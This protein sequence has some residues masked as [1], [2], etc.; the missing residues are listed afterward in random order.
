MII[1]P[2]RIGTSSTLNARSV[3]KSIRALAAT[4]PVFFVCF[5]LISPAASAQSPS[6]PVIE[7]TVQNLTNS[8]NAST[9][10]VVAVVGSHVYV[11]WEEKVPGSKHVTYFQTSPDNGTDWNA[12]IA[13]SSMPG[14]AS[15]QTSAV[16]IAAEGTYVF[17]TWEQN[18]QTAYAISSDYG[19]TFKYNLFNVTGSLA[20]TMSGEAVSACGTYAYFT[21]GDIATTGKGPIIFAQAHD[22][23][24]GVFKF[25]TPKQISSTTSSHREDESDCSGNHVYV[26]WDS[27]YFTVSTNNGAT[28][29]PV[30]QLRPAGGSGGSLSR[31][32]MISANGTN[33]Y[34]TFP[35]DST[36]DGS[37]QTFI[38]VSNNYGASFAPAK[39]LSYGHLSNAREVQVTSDH[40][41]VY[42]TSRGQSAN[43]SGTQQ[44]VYVS[45]NNGSTFT[46]PHL[47]GGTKLPNP[48]N[49][50]GGVAIDK[51]NGNVYVQWIHNP[52][53]KSLKGIQQIF[54]SASQD[55]GATWSTTQQLSNSPV[56]G[57]LGYGDPAGGQGP[58]VAAN[59]GRVF[60]VWVDLSTNN[61]DI[62]FVASL[63]G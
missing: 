45:N 50:F 47:V 38:V 48:E 41:D 16:Q 51:S 42:I 25:T 6:Q 4:L 19:A 18:N 34:V 56:N 35:S 46:A 37:Y 52:P 60:S 40:S 12:Q 39:D 8:P 13:F 58:Q 63:A 17:L 7:G 22:I 29:A 59:L 53:G 54:L 20:G 24:A 49:G 3:S 36:P 14:G 32:P 43:Y 28:W 5:M 44:Y 9:A 61:G 31:E 15:P 1:F 26:V 30:K 10:P 21:W 23:G 57:T 55:F 2:R 27:I 11:A 33:V 62:D